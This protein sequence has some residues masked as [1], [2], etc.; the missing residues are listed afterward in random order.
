MLPLPIFFPSSFVKNAFLRENG[1]LFLSQ[2]ED[3]QKSKIAFRKSFRNKCTL[4]FSKL[5]LHEFALKF[6]LIFNAL[7]F[8]QNALKTQAS[9]EIHF[10]EKIYS[11]KFF[12]LL[13]SQKK[14]LAKIV[15]LTSYVIECLWRVNYFSSMLNY[16]RKILILNIVI[17][18]SQFPK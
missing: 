16:G 3:F 8:C 15:Q 1:F 5:K 17:L 11:A 4:I 6:D 9:L 7:E 18:P 2:L 12:L 13:P 14:K 10:E